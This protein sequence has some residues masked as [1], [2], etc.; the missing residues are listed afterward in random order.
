M[1]I[2][3]GDGLVKIKILGIGCPSCRRLEADVIEVVSRLRLNIEVEYVDDL[4]QILQYRPLVLPGLVVADKLV[5]CGYAGKSRAESVIK[6]ALT[7]QPV[8]DQDTKD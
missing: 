5:A 7:D 6:A 8:R 3:V 4:E 1:G 2:S